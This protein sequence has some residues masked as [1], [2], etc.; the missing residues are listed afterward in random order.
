MNTR[1]EPASQTDC[2]LPP[3][4][5]ARCDFLAALVEALEEQVSVIDDR[6]T[7]I[8]VNEAWRRFGEE[9]GVPPNTQWLGQNYLNAC[10]QAK[11]DPIAQRVAN[12][13]ERMLSA[14]P[15]SSVTVE[16]PCHSL[17]A[18]RWFLMRATR[19][20]TAQGCFVVVVHENITRRKQAEQRAA[21]LSMRDPL[22]GLANRR[23]FNHD[24]SRIWLRCRR[25]HSPLSLLSIDIDYFKRLN[26]TF[27][28][29]A[30]DACLKSIARILKRHARRPEDLAARIGGE[31]FALLLPDTDIHI[32]HHIAEHLR[33][34]IA[35]HSGA[36]GVPHAT[37]TA[38]I[39]LVG[40]IPTH[41]MQPDM[42][43]A[44]ADVALYSAKCGGRDRVMLG[45]A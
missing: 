32:A 19:M 26:D 20:T 21:A 45:V 30:G 29:P 16:Y 3:G 17:Q 33:Q 36:E 10:R 25:S 7:I 37:I 13:I 15:G 44:A 42:L 18:Q 22:T 38:S 9:N 11:G 14:T 24:L 31:E 43:V 28:H 6:G 41:T 8:Y 5:E 35:L 23:A 12:G 1:S 4:L 34:A 40:T 27:G 39:G 2:F